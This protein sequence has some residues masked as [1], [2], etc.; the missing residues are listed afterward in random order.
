MNGCITRTEN[1][2]A[3]SLTCGHEIMMLSLSAHASDCSPVMF[4]F[5]NT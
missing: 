5:S 1:V 2:D 3:I 4:H